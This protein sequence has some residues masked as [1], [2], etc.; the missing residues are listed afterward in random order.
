M[1]IILSSVINILTIFTLHSQISL[2]TEEFA[3]PPN[4]SESSGVIYFNNK[5]ITHNDSGKENNLYEVDTISGLVT[6]TITISNAVNIDWEDITHDENSIYIADIGNNSG[7]RTDLKI[8]KISKSDYTASNS[9]VADIIEISYTNQSDFTSKTNNTEWDAEALVSFNTTH[10]V[11]FSKNWVNGN[12]N[13]YLV[14]KTPGNYGL[15]PLVT[16]L[17]S[18]GLI[19]GGTFNPL[20]A[21]LYLIGYN[22]ILQPFVW[23]SE[24][25]T[26]N[27]VFS[28]TNTQTFLSALGFEQ[29]EA[30]TYINENKYYVTS[31]S[32]NVN[33]LSDY[34]K[35]VSF[36][37]NDKVLLD[38]NTK[39]KNE[40]VLYPNPID[41]YF[42]INSDA[43]IKVEIFDTKYTR[44][45]VGTTPKVRTSKLNSGFYFIKIYFND[46]TFVIKKVV[47]K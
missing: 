37:T 42:Q 24:N 10:L 29:V 26:N 32:F 5:L 41:N 2:V 16:T 3:L 46:N 36:S 11:L 8:Y 43:V 47:K 4:L 28:G 7:D 27:D 12:T 14:P 19:T 15:S 18:G 35:A 13:A 23:E 31:E 20:T 9:V 33:G 39:K 44:L 1:K 6:R 21:K 30:I 17:N 40:V 34:A 38:F 22:S 25:F 45:Y